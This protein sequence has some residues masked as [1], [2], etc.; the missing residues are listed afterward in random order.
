MRMQSLLGTLLVLMFFANQAQAD[1]IRVA[2]A[3]NF[4]T[5]LRDLGNAWERISG[6]RIILVTGSTGKHYAQIRNGAPFEAFFAAD[7]KRPRLLEAQGLALPGSR[8]T[9]ARGRLIL[10]SPDP[11]RI[12]PAGE[13]LAHGDF[14]HIALANPKLAPYG[15]AAEQLLRTLGLWQRLQSRMVRGE[16]IGQAFQFV[17]SGNAAL[18]FVARSQ[19]RDPGSAAAGSSWEPPQSLYDPIDQ[20]AVL[21]KDH[22]GAREFLAF[23]RS[24]SGRA[25]IRSHGYA[26]P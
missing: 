17:H 1:P 25:I 16:N 20:E 15:R 7:A 21:L 8:F 2:V 11:D 22:P 5:A 9:Y 13:V 23:I 19:V 14:R 18:G 4:T 10:W 24:P 6:Q 3:S 12:D 26:L